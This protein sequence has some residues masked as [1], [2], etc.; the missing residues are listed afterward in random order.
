MKIIFH[1]FLEILSKDFLVL[2]IDQSIL[3]NPL[4]LMSPQLDEIMIRFA[5][6]MT[7]PAYA[8]EDF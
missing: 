7:G 5:A 6:E 8:V 3:E 1:N 4:A 2:A